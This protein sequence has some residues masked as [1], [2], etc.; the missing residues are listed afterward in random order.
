MK[1]SVLSNLEFATQVLY[2]IGILAGLAIAGSGISWSAAGAE[3]IKIGGTGMALGTMSA[4][5][6][7]YARS[8]PDTKIIVLPSL[9]SSGG[10][11]A[12]ASGAIQIAVAGRALSGSEIGQGL[13]AVEYGRAPFVFA[14]SVKTKVTGLT[15]PQLVDIYSGK[16]GLWPDGTR[17]R[18]VLRPPYDGDSET[19]RNL[20]AEMREALGNAEKRP[21]MHIAVNDQDN[22]DSLE[23]IAGAI[24]V[25]TL[26]QIIS[27][28]R[29]LKALSLNGVEPSPA[30]LASGSYPMY[31][32]LF[33]VTGPRTSPAAKKFVAFVQSPAGREILSR[34][35]HW[36]R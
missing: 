16:T 21:G 17:I 26:V 34:T 5:A 19:V 1:I 11:K 33:L 36:L 4:L 13:V 12:V 3:E 20:S 9:G 2:R 10:I 23:R 27:E 18:L 22:A 24:G 30:T 25:T 8:N 6:E 7:A 14:V 31:R 28:Q 15:L 29:Q 32:T 35:G